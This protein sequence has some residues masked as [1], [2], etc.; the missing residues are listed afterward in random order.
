[1]VDPQ[2]AQQAPHPLN[3]DRL[4]GFFPPFCIR[5]LK[6]KARIAE[7]AS[8]LP[9]DP[10]HIRDFGLRA[11]NLCP[12][13][14]WKWIR[15]WVLTENCTALFFPKKK[16]KTKKN[17]LLSFSLHLLLTGRHWELNLPQLQSS[18]VS[19]SR[20]KRGEYPVNKSLNDYINRVSTSYLLPPPSPT[21]FFAVNTKY[22]LTVGDLP[23]S[24]TYAPVIAT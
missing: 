17:C 22:R 4:C 18:E 12:P 14:Q 5:M 19:L 24:A 2:G 13:P 1:M 21:F 11:H 20:K 9:P 3:Y 8:K 6:N 23:E 15:P 7:R 10:S 16:K